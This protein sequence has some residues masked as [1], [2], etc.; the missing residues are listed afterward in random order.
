M[1]VWFL[2]SFECHF[3]WMSFL[4]FEDHFLSSFL[5]SIHLTCSLTSDIGV[6][7]IGTITTIYKNATAAETEN[8]QKTRHE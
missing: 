7:F 1:I 8:D 2:L 4:S 3:F 5:S 6:P